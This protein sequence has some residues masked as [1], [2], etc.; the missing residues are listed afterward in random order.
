MKIKVAYISHFSDLKMGGQRSMTFLIENL[1]RNLVEPIAIMPEKGELSDKLESI[2]CRCFFTPVTSLKPRNWRQFKVVYNGFKSIIHC[3]KPD[4]IH[5]DY[6]ADVVFSYFAKR[7]LKSKLIWHIRW[8]NPSPRDILLQKLVDGVIAVSEGAGKRLSESFR[9]SSKYRT[10]YNGIDISQ[11]KPINNNNEFRNELNIPL[12]KFV[13]I[14]VGVLKEGKGILDIADAMN[15]IKQNNKELPELLYIG[16][17]A[18]PIIYEILIEKIETYG[19]QNNIKLLGQKNDIYKYMQAAD[20]LLI[21]SHEG[22]EGMP[23]VAIEAMAC[24]LPVIGTD[25]SGTNEA[26]TNIS[27]ILVQEKNPAQLADAM[28]KLMN[29]DAYR[30][31]LST[32]ARERAELHFDITQHA[33]KV[34]DFYMEILSGKI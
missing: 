1:D 2:G 21:P 14:F 8:T 10:I 3:E 9:N 4:I 31:K 27:G 25:I 12:N 33:K 15:I 17:K 34:Q 16:S 29:D 5:P 24:G 6:D 28:I 11:F 30:S 7:K 32:G 23:R 13:F 26:I 18:N 19:L 20:A 22:N